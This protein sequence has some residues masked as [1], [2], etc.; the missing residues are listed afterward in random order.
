MLSKKERRGLVQ[1]IEKSRLEL[2]HGFIFVES[3]WRV[4]FANHH[5]DVDKVFYNK[6]LCSYVL[7]ELKITKLMPEAVGQLKLYML[8]KE[9]LIRQVEIVFERCHEENQS[10]GG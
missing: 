6:I 7:I 4:T 9:Q 8:D 5:Y 1:Q 10:R 2:G 3:Q